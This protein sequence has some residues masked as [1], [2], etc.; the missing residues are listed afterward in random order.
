MFEGFFLNTNKELGE[1]KYMDI[2][3]QDVKKLV[4]DMYLV[5]YMNKKAISEEQRL[6]TADITDL[7]LSLFT[8][9][10]IR[11]PTYTIQK[12]ADLK[13]YNGDEDEPSY[14]MLE[15]LK[16][17]SDAL[18][19]VISYYF[20]GQRKTYLTENHM[21]CL[22]IYS[23]YSEKTCDVFVV[24]KSGKFWIVD[25]EC[26]DLLLVDFITD[27]F[28]EPSLD[29]KN[30]LEKIF[31]DNKA[32]HDTVQ[33]KLKDIA[34]EL[35]SEIMS[36]ATEFRNGA[37]TFMDFLGWKGLWQNRNG[38]NHLDSVSKLI[39]QI[40]EIAQKYTLEVFPYTTGLE[41]SKFISISDTIAIFTPMIGKR[42]KED[43]LELHAKIARY[44]L[45]NCVKNK[46]AIRGAIAFGKYN[47]KD[48]IMIGPG[49]DECASW[50]E[51]CDWIGVH[52]TPSAELIINSSNTNKISG[53]E[54]YQV[55]VKRGYPQVRYCVKWEVNSKDF[56]LL[57]DEVPALLPEISSKYLN[58]YK[59]LHR[60]EV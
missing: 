56:E 28:G 11:K 17:N 45:E 18:H 5:G 15:F 40:K 35:S 33:N 47:T 14:S 23:A 7:T 2:T 29:L 21:F 1:N 43:I 44:I 6:L 8:K 46:Y 12:N 59:F 50:H 9:I 41:I 58:T 30:K 36:K 54:E 48:N 4:R 19:E 31:D 34:S 16:E 26:T 38:E 55:P 53:I 51:L 60:K 3:L 27:F 20:F 42:K 10:K 52:L 39:N 32:D 57:T 25:N 24:S 49:I 37:I 13:K 22:E